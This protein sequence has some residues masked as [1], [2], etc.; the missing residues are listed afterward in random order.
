MLSKLIGIDFNMKLLSSFAKPNRRIL[1]PIPK[2]WRVLLDKSGFVSDFF[3]NR[4]YW[5][6]YVLF[7]F[8]YGLYLN[9]IRF[10]HSF[11]LI[12]MKK[13]NN[14]DKRKLYWI[15]CSNK[16]HERDYNWCKENDDD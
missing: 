3:L 5:N 10:F 9:L 1:Y 14:T 13:S 2:E 4:I 8:C 12:M 15:D 16:E 7:I 6:L 11:I